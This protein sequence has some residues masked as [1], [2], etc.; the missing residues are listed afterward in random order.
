MVQVAA[1]TR[2]IYTQIPTSSR[3]ASDTYDVA[4]LNAYVLT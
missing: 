1:Q 4:E 3:L 2:D